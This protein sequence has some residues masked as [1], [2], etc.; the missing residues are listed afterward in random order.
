MA[1]Q[2]QPASVEGS[3]QQS[4]PLAGTLVVCTDVGRSR[5]HNEDNFLI[6]DVRQHTKL[7]A[8]KELRYSFASPGLLVGVADGMGGHS[9]GQVAA[10]LCV[11][12]LPAEFLKR[13]P[14]KPGDDT[15]WDALLAQ[16]VHATNEALLTTAK[17]NREYE[18]MGTTLTTAL[19]L[20]RQA[21]I[22]QVGDSRCYLFRGGNLTQLTQDQTVF[23]TLGEEERAALRDTP[24]ENMLLQAVGAMAKLE[25]ITTDI[26]LRPADLLLFCSD[27]LYKVVTNEEMAEVLKGEGG[28]KKKADV[29]IERANNAGGPDNITVI[30]C[31][32]GD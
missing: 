23:N 32:V 9:S 7:E 27:G 1:Q 18:G 26:Q 16:A 19:F 14:E 29:L 12:T 24:F 5:S 8:G 10:Q 28:L 4:A 13:L 6:I 15:D 11:E 2:S 31:Q 21:R 17:G 22:A 25:V 20:G 3:P 30:L